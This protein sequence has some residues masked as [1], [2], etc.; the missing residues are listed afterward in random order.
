VKLL[1]L[2]VVSSFIALAGCPSDPPKPMAVPDAAPPKDSALP[3]RASAGTTLAPLSRQVLQHVLVAYAGAANVPG[4]VKRTKEEARMR[5]AEVRKRALKGEQFTGLATEYS[6]DPPT[7]EVHGFLNS[8]Q[9]SAWPK[10][11]VT[12]AAALP[13]GGTSD[14]VETELGFHVI[15]R[16]EDLPPR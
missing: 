5:A 11:F 10:A 14:V 7:R 9:P 12:A 8:Y 4:Y 3:P 6:D 15:Q 2:A 13:V 1:R 16:S